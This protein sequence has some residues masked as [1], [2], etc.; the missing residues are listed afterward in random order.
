MGLVVL[1]S[2]PRTLSVIVFLVGLIK[3]IPRTTNADNAERTARVRLVYRN[4]L[5][6]Q[7]N[8]LQVHQGDQ[9]LP[10]RLREP[11]LE[12]DAFLRTTE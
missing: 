11:I 4:P 2:K 9:R 3:A 5:S 10:L 1:T 12:R 8:A 6:G 7:L